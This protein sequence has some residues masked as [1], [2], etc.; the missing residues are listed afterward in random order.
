MAGLPWV[1][2]HTLRHSC[3]SMLFRAGLNAKQVQVW[4]GHHS[5]AFTLATY[6][7]LLPDDMPDADFLDTIVGGQQ[8][9][10]EPTQT[11]AEDAPAAVQA[12]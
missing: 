9:T 6:I 7:H 2:F 10:T 3:A 8:R 11:E 5:P 1:T 12:L 4:L